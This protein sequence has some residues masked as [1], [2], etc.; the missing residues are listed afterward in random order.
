MFHIEMSI[1]RANPLFRKK[2]CGK[3]PARLLLLP[4]AHI[5]IF[6]GSDRTLALPGFTTDYKIQSSIRG[7][8]W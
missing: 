6:F 1:L 4:L 7:K 8:T 2:T 5:A 3:L